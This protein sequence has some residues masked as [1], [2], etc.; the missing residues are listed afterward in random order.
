MTGA[1]AKFLNTDL[2][3]LAHQLT[4]SPKRL[5]LGQT[6]GIGRLLGGL[7]D[8]D[9]AYPYDFV[10]YHI[11]EYRKRGPRVEMPGDG[12]AMI[13][14]KALISDLVSMADA[15]TR[16]A[17]IPATDLQEPHKSHDEL[18]EELNVSTKTVRRW[19]SYGHLGRSPRRC[20]QACLSK[21]IDRHLRGQTRGARQEG[22]RIPPTHQ[23]GTDADRRTGA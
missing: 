20:M 13:P 17:G 12:K 8:P 6:A 1:M 15:I 7:V 18:A 23:D 3:E 9:R 4:L 5:R 21:V 2:A 22:I 14:G 19:R 10:C 16:K 11:T